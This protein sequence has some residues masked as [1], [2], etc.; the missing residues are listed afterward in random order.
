MNSSHETCRARPTPSRGPRRDSFLQAWARAPAVRAVLPRADRVHLLPWERADTRKLTPKDLWQQLTERSLGVSWMVTHKTVTESGNRAPRAVTSS[1][2]VVR[3]RVTQ[4][5]PVSNKS[6]STDP[7]QPAQ[8]AACGPD[9][10]PA[11]QLE[12]GSVNVQPPP[13]RPAPTHHGERKYLHLSGTNTSWPFHGATS[14]QG[15]RLPGGPTPGPHPS[16]NLGGPVIPRTHRKPCSQ[17]PAYNWAGCASA[18]LRHSS[19]SHRAPTPGP[20]G[21]Q[22][23]LIPAAW[24][25]TPASLP[26][27]DSGPRPDL[28]A[29]II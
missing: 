14:Q 12:V 7:G 19:P 21:L 2:M 27:A 8:G 29:T 17:L 6:E 1:R 23:V 9:A 28:Q 3:W 5:Q 15:S 10:R 13:Q 26:A 20:P 16:S 22:R 24:H 11:A 25:T 4:L 18:C